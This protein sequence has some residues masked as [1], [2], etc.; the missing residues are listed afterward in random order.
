M[1]NDVE[2]T[3]SEIKQ[4]LKKLVLGS[5]FLPGFLILVF[6]S[7]ST[8]PVLQQATRGAVRLSHP[9][10]SAGNQEKECLTTVCTR[11]ANYAPKTPANNE[12]LVVCAQKEDSSGAFTF[13][14]FYEVWVEEC[15]VR[16]TLRRTWLLS[17]NIQFNSLL[18]MEPSLSYN[19]KYDKRNASHFLRPAWK[20]QKAKSQSKFRESHGGNKVNIVVQSSW[21]WKGVKMGHLL[22]N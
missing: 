2:H 14:V 6:T 10:L 1:K 19:L 4:N 11:L 16:L 20:F 8:N 13:L 5:Y 17:A 7:S 12:V 22:I 9:M 3:R 18:Q 15:W 21:S